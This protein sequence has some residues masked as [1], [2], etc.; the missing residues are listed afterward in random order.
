M[1]VTVSTRSQRMA[2]DYVALAARFLELEEEPVTPCQSGAGRTQRGTLGWWELDNK[3][4]RTWINRRRSTGLSRA[5][6]WQQQAGGR[7]KA[8]QSIRHLPVESATPT[9]LDSLGI[10]PNE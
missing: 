2:V 10:F 7:R 3:D 4:H 1:P 8:L 9:I 5:P 6:K